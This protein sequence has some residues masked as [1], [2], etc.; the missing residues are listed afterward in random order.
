MVRRSFRARPQPWARRPRRCSAY[1]RRH[2]LLSGFQVRQSRE[3][4]GLAS[5]HVD[6]PIELRRRS[7]GPSGQHRRQLLLETPAP[8]SQRG[9]C[10]KAGAFHSPRSSGS[11]GFSEGRKDSTTFSLSATCRA[12]AESRKENPAR[13]NAVQA[14]S[15]KQKPGTPGTPGPRN[16]ISPS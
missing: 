8:I 15:R 3:L 6:F 2:C 1:V 10:L 5:H 12:Q 9:D 4:R 11:S 7:V 13:L 16:G 14:R